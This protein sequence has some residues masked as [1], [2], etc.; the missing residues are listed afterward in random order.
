MEN[1]KEFVLKATHLNIWKWLGLFFLFMI[2]G[3]IVGLSIPVVRN[4]FWPRSILIILTMQL[5]V[6]LTL[7]LI[8]FEL[9]IVCDI[10][11][12]SIYKNNKVVYEKPIT[13][14]EKFHGGNIDDKIK[15]M[16]E[17][18]FFFVEGERFHFSNILSSKEI[19][20]KQSLVVKSLVK[21]FIDEYGFVKQDHYTKLGKSKY[22]FMY[23]NPKYIKDE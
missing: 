13:E 11:K 5:L 18:D 21:Y 16:G 12:L 6:L 2:I 4:M 20:L 19:Q 23:V 15:N 8:K 22:M 10:D 9:R 3:G 7:Y 14:I 17:L 1:K